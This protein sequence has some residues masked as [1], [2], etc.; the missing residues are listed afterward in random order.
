MPPD[1]SSRHAVKQIGAAG[2][3]AF[4]AGGILRGQTADIRVAGRPVEIAVV[5]LSPSTV[6]LSV[7]PI[8]GGRPSA[9]PAEWRA[10]SAERRQAGGPIAEPLGL[11]IDSRRRS[12]RPLHRRAADAARRDGRGVSRAEADARCGGRRSVVSAAEGAAARTRRRRTAVR[13]QGI[14]RSHAQ[15]P[16]RLPAA[17]ARRPRAD[18]VAGRHRRLGDVHP[19][20]ARRVR[21]HRRR[22]A[23]FTPSRRRRC[24]STCSS[25]RRAIPQ[26]SSAEYARITGLPELP[27]L[28]SFGYMQSHRTLAGPDE[29]MWVARTFREKKLPCDALIYLGTEFTPSGWNTRNGEFT[30]KTENFPDPKAM[31][32][33]LHAHALQGRAAHRHRGPPHDAAP[34][35]IRA[36]RTRPCRAAARRTT[37]GRTTA[38]C[39]ATGRITSR[40]STS[41]STAGGPIRV[42]ASTR[43]RGLARH[44]HVLGGPAALAAERAAVRAAS[45]RRTPACSATARSSGRATSTRRGRR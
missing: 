1:I 44:P 29:V 40:S 14:G 5:S 26:S 17:D 24:R 18:S 43:R 10:R 6:R 12:G 35:T 41:A 37:A 16:G 13:S 4:L 22:R 33:E 36:R 20:S 11:Q 34:S 9:V 32:D 38:R 7:L 19:S 25:R 27:P 15:R 31:I 23:A 30:W 8:E 28:W 3:G 21:F 2:A 39:R 42:T 45:Q